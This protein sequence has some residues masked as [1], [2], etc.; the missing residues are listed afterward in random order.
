[1]GR[2]QFVNRKLLKCSETMFLKERLER[3][4][5]FSTII[6]LNDSRNLEKF[7]CMKSKGTRLS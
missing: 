6:S 3:I 1:M 4:C 2:L 5:T 7:Q